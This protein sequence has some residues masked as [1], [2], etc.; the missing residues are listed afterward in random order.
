MER[1]ISAVTLYRFAGVLVAAGEDADTL[2]GELRRLGAK[3]VRNRTTG[4][5]VAGMPDCD[6]WR[7]A[8]LRRMARLGVA[9]TIVEGEIHREIARKIANA[10]Y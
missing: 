4:V 7:G 2:D 1:L 6:P 3:R 10:G 5:V 8:L 9:V